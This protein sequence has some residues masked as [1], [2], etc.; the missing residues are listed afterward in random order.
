MEEQKRLDLWSIESKI[1]AKIDATI[2]RDQLSYKEKMDLGQG[3]RFNV[4]ISSK[5][6]SCISLHQKFDPSQ[7]DLSFNFGSGTYNSF[8]ADNQGNHNSLH[9]HFESGAQEFNDRIPLSGAMT[10]TE[11]IGSVFRKAEEIIPLHFPNFFLSGGG[12][13]GTA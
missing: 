2:M 12:F 6:G 8:R 9:L 11:M 4:S 5:T 7:I 10:V 13:V 3:Q 1:Y